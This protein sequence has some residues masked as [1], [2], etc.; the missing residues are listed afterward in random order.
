MAN[1]KLCYQP[2]LGD[3][4]DYVQAA[5]V[6]AGEL[7]LK[8]YKEHWLLAYRQTEGYFILVIENGMPS[9]LPYAAYQVTPNRLGLKPGLKLLFGKG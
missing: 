8:K 5:I 2:C 1:P 3:E 6:N 9:T 7:L 4:P